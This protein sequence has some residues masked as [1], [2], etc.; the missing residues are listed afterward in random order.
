MEFKPFNL[1]LEKDLI[2]Q[3]KIRAIQEDRTVSEITAELYRK[4]LSEEKKE[5]KNKNK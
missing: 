3:I 1:R 4:Y 2:A 5:A